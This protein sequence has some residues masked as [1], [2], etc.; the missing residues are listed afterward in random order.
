MLR[1][2]IIG[3]EDTPQ[4]MLLAN[5]NEAVRLLGIDAKTTTVTDWEDILNHNIIQT[6]ALIV[7]NQMLSQGFVPSASEIKTILKAFLPDAYLP[8]KTTHSPDGSSSLL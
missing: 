6:P 8:L 4:K 7:R 3:A 2:K 5:V 1:I